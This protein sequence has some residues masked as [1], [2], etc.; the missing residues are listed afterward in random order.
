MQTLVIR[1]PRADDPSKVAQ[2]ITVDAAGMPV[3]PPVSGTLTQA[4]PSAFGCVVIG[5][6]S[7]IDVVLAELELPVK[8]AAKL[9]QIAP[10]ALEDQL[11]GNVEDHHF[12]IGKRVTSSSRT[13][14]AAITHERMRSIIESL[15]AAGIQPDKLIPDTAVLPVTPNGLTIVVEKG[16]IYTQRAEHPAA[17]LDVE[18]LIEGLQLAL[19]SGAEAREHV[20]LYITPAE[21]E[22]DQDLIEGLREFTASLQ[23][24]LLSNDALPLLAAAAVTQPTMNLLQGK[25]APHSSLQLSLGPWKIAAALAGVFVAVHLGSNLYQ[26]RQLSGEEKRLDAA[27]ARAFSQVM[28]GVR[29]VDARPQVQGHLNSLRAG[30]SASGL[31]QGLSTLGD[32]LAQ[33][34]G[35]RLEALVYGNNT[36]DLRVTAPNVD[37]LDRIQHAATERG[38]TA[39]IQS[40]TPRDNRVDGRLQ[41]KSPGA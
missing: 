19:A 41:L 32:A 14:V 7:G 2:W 31:L 4:A 15:Q 33:A 5:L 38:L 30:A 40:A 6:V 35:A 26:W 29:L 10:F 28:P 1:L 37:A 39:K 24:K 25:Y 22:Q 17:V 20:M 16:C 3:S 27:L 9:A 34:P 11:A 23:V 8:N 21:Y 13:P 36:L 12:V 18:P